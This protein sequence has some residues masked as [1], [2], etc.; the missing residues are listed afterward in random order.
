MQH[1]GKKEGISVMEAVDNLTHMAEI[2]LNAPSLELGAGKLTEE[3][4]REQLNLLSWQSPE[5][6]VYNRERVRETFQVILNY[7]KHLYEKDKIHL[8][9]ADTQRGVQAIMILVNEAAQKVDQCTEM[10]KGEKEESI[11]Q[12]KEY[13]ELQH[14][15]LSKVYHKFNL[16]AETDIPWHEDW[17]A[18]GEEVSKDTSRQGLK[19]LETIRNDKEYEL[20]LIK[21]EDGRPFFNK[22]LLRHLR[23]VGEFDET[24]GDMGD[25]DPFLRLKMLE[26]RDLHLSAQEILHQVAPYVDDYLKDAMKYKEIEFV[27][28]INKALMALMLA[29]NSHNMMQNTLGKSSL[30]YY[31][32]FQFYLRK[33]ISSTEYHHYMTNPPDRKDRFFQTLYTLTHSLCSGYFTRSG[34]H[35]EM[36]AF[37]RLLIEKGGQGS[38]TRPQTQSPLALW[39]NLLDENEHIRY[40]LKHYPNGPVLRAIDVFRSET[41]LQGFDPL[42]Q[43]NHPAQLYTVV[44]D[45]MHLSCLRIPAPVHQEYIHKAAPVDEFYGFLRSLGKEGMQQRHLMVNLQDRTSWQEHARCLALEKIPAQAEFNQS[46]VVVTLPKNA[47]FYFQSGPY[48]NLNDAK[49]F[50]SLFEAQIESAEQCG[51]FFPSAWNK[52]AFESFAKDAMKMIHRVFF[53]GKDTLIHKNRL[54]FIEIFYLFLL[55][56]VI[57]DFKP[58]SISFTCKDSVDTGAAASA[59]FYSFMKIMNSAQSWSK[60]EKDFLLWLIY[61]PALVLRERAIDATRF[62]RMTSALSVVQAELEAHRE[63]VIAACAKL[64]ETPFFKDMRIQDAS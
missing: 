8:R 12:I 63:Q 56:K 26:D 20:F 44:N 41:P 27:A 19:D 17:S 40:L 22:D 15:Y 13:K 3:Q 38:E 24:L 1:R 9:D 57:E 35:K 39:N 32:D 10:F 5:Y 33:A 61:S 37:I 55:L 48:V 14:F 53:G 60:E 16:P 2:D 25:E 51:F 64:Y 7:L 18:Q 29:A 62:N 11:T 4:V 34:K 47:D 52:K 21:R 49:E 45:Q 50:I 36:I 43:I 30:N 28:S 31:S 42:A 6:I 59:E 23:L 58:D 54:D 46:L